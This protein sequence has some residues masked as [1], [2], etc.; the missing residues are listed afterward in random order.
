MN[1]SDLRRK[2][3]SGSVVAQSIL[4][5]CYLDGIDVEPNY[6]EAFRLLSAAAQQGASRAMLNLAR[7]HAEGLGIPKNLVEAIRLYERAAQA[8]EFFAQVELGRLYSRGI[9]VSPDPE[10]A[11]KWYSAAVA[12]E[13]LRDSRPEGGQH[14]AG[15]GYQDRARGQG[16]D[17]RPDHRAKGI[18]LGGGCR[19]TGFRHGDKAGWNVF[20]RLRPPVPG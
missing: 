7:I 20:P 14:Q 3:E 12:Q 9:G 10:M 11:L 16:G 18:V 2:A 15:R 1:I 6:D 8:G 19:L 4:G 17:R 5:I 13:V